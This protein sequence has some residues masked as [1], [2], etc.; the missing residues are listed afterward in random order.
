MIDKDYIQ[1]IRDDD[2]YNNKKTLIKRAEEFK[3]HTYNTLKKTLYNEVK[4][5]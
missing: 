4:K 1:Y 3:K 5:K 2:D